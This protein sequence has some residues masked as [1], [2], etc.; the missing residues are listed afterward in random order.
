M[1]S[2]SKDVYI[3]ITIYTGGSCKIP[4]MLGTWGE[5]AVVK[6]QTCY[7]LEVRW[8]HLGHWTLFKAYLFN[9]LR[10]IDKMS[11]AKIY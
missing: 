4:D 8:A 2:L 3:F 10:Y 11:K 1:F 6:Y 9:A 5:G 7:A